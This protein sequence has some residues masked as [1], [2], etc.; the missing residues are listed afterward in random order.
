[1][2][3]ALKRIP[4]KGGGFRFPLLR[5]VQ[6]NVSARMFFAHANA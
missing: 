2:L 5:A 6:A 1:M 3:T 4:S